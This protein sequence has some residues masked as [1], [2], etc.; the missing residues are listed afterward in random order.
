L[1]SRVGSLV[2]AEEGDVP[3]TIE[4]RV[5]RWAR[6][7]DEHE[8]IDYH[9]IYLFVMYLSEKLFFTYA[10]TSGAELHFL[11]RLRNWLNQVEDEDDQKTLL[12]LVANVFFCGPEEFK[13]LYRSALNGPILRWLIDD[14]HLDIAAPDVSFQSQEAI[15]GTWFCGLTESMPLAD[16]YHVNHLR[17]REYRPEMRSLCA[18]GGISAKEEILRYVNAKGIERIVLLED[19]VGSGTQVAKTVKFVA[20]LSEEIRILVVPL[21][22]CPRGFEQGV[23]L[24]AQFPN[25]KFDPVVVLP[26]G[27]FVK[28]AKQGEELDGELYERIRQLVIRLHGYVT[29]GAPPDSQ[30]EPY[31]PFGFKD[32][33]GMVVC[34]ANCPNN[35]L[36]VIHYQSP[37]W[38]PIFPRSPRV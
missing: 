26:K 17:N 4:E 8:R 32:T 18:F 7:L 20:S 15:E 12:R 31:G 19:F 35:T 28:P 33:G 5:R 27:I 29:N 34:Y 9:D 23:K 14:A 16:F 22:V 36:P 3:H 24:E 6:L 2:V 30:K 11:V 37:S 13:S 1:S 10:P 21:L 25:V 38:K